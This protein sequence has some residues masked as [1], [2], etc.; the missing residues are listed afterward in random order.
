MPSST[1]GQH[2]RQWGDRYTFWCFRSVRHSGPC[3]YLEAIVGG[4]VIRLDPE[5][6]DEQL[7]APDF[8]GLWADVWA[9]L[10]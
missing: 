8:A 7:S 9:A 2:G 4:V 6:T 5:P 10:R 3:A 1:D